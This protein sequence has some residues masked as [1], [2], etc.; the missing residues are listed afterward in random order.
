MMS[1][2]LFIKGTPQSEENSRSTQVAR[3]FIN[4]YKQANPTDEVIELDLYQMD[5][6]LIDADVLNGWGKLRAGETLTNSEAQKVEAIDK[7][8]AQ[9]MSADKF[10]IQSSM[11]NLGIQPLLKAYF[12]TAMIAGK[13]FK[14]GAEG[15]IGLMTGKKAIHIHGTGGIY[16]NTTGIEHTDSYVKSVLGFMGIDVEPTI[17]VEGID[18][19]PSRK[20]EIMAVANQQAKQAA[21]QF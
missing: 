20:E 6:P 4:E 9:F 21:K 10:I 12:D 2:I 15:P 19:N 14:Y 16:S 3:T 11:W 1:K 18:H 5:V 17:F 8:T 7:F 13:T